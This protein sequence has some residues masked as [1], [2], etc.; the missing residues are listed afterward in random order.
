MSSCAGK[1]LL[2]KQGW[3]SIGSIIW[4]W[5]H[6]ELYYFGV[7]LKDICEKDVIKL[8][9]ILQDKGKEY[10]LSQVTRGS[11]FQFYVFKIAGG[12]FCLFS[13]LEICHQE[14]KTISREKFPGVIW[15]I[16][17]ITHIY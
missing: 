6:S 2:V 5:F 8:L 7:G 4:F 12:A 13:P 1:W 11:D 16:I 14:E 15:R 9:P 17:F 3:A 10:P